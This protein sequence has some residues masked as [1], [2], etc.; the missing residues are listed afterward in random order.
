MVKDFW[1]APLM[2]CHYLCSF[3]LRVAQRPGSAGK[4]A[5]LASAY[6]PCV[7]FAP[8]FAG[9]FVIIVGRPAIALSILDAIKV[10]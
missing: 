3:G 6:A 1:Q 4:V 10:N 7:R 2:P 9:N 8:C 5:A